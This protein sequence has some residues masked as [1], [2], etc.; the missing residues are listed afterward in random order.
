MAELTC[1]LCDDGRVFSRPGHLANH[2]KWKHADESPPVPGPDLP[3]EGMS[4][5]GDGGEL[6]AERR[7][8]SP[9]LK[10]SEPEPRGLLGR[11]R[12]PKALAPTGEKRPGSK[13]RVPTVDF[14]AST[15]VG[16]SQVV[17]RAGY[18][19]TAR[20]MAWSGPIAGDII[21]DATKDT[22][23]DRVVQP[24]ARN[25]EKWEKLFR[26]VE[27]WG[28]IAFAEAAASAE[29]N[30]TSP[31]ER[32]SAA[33]RRAAGLQIARNGLTALLPDMAK[34]ITKQRDTE[35][36]AAEAIAELMPELADL[37][38]D[39]SDPVG[40]LLDMLFAPPPIPQPEPAPA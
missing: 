20:A 38:V 2:R 15:V 9:E 6:F 1:D 26:L 3:L 31:E 21:E 12:K 25:A 39:M 24:L 37:G 23:I 29:V 35:R 13:R 11:L 34:A 14:W 27:F 7:P 10:E 22:A 17:S 5:T 33:T 4:A 16:A 36:K 32:A 40:G 28:G 18:V 19:P 30:A 8:G